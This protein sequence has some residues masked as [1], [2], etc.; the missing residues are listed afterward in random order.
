MVAVLADVIALIRANHLTILRWQVVLGDLR[1]QGRHPRTPPSRALPGVW[2][3]FARLLDWH[4]GAREEICGLA[5]CDMGLWSRHQVGHM[6]KDHQYI[7]EVLRETCLQPPSSPLWWPLVETGISAWARQADQEEHDL[8]ADIR[9][10]LGPH[11]RLRLGRQWVAFMNDQILGQFPLP[12][13][14][15]PAC[16]LWQRQILAVMPGCTHLCIGP[17][18]CTCPACTSSVERVLPALPAGIPAGIFA[19]A[20]DDAAVHDPGDPHRHQDGCL[21]QELARGREC[22]AERGRR[23]TRR[24]S[25]ALSA[26]TTVDRLIST[27][28]AAIGNTIPAQASAPAASGMATTLYPAAHQRFAASC[29]VREGR[30]DLQL[31][32]HLR[33]PF[34]HI[35]PVQDVAPGLHQVVDR[36]AVPRAFQQERGKQRR[37]LGEVEL[38]SAIPALCGELG[39]RVDHQP[40]ALVQ[41]KQ[42]LLLPGLCRLGASPADPG[43]HRSA[44][45]KPDLR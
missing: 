16:Q 25:C 20:A 19:C 39:R 12:H 9:A 18:I 30:L 45:A 2:N 17:L 43:W 36:P 23:S 33:D 21:A 4:M 15:M 29:A 38:Q 6:H 5:M 22:Y 3:I 7:R 28:P 14:G 37:G 42:H 32:E 34:H 8:L 10:Q 41:S 35:A 1:W 26:T 40:L 44:P 11:A 27:A 31:A 13:E 24:S